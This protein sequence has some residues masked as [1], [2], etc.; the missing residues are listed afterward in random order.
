VALNQSF[1]ENIL[2]ML[3]ETEHGKLLASCGFEN[4]LKICS[5]LSVTNTV[6]FFNGNALQS[7][8]V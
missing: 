6:P 7:L 3:K 4:D 2:T 8:K 1:G 5:E